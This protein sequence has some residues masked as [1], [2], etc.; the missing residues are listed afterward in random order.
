MKFI[1]TSQGI[2]SHGHMTRHRPTYVRNYIYG[3]GKS[4]IY[5]VLIYKIFCL[6]YIIWKTKY[7]FKLNHVHVSAFEN[8]VQFAHRCLP[9]GFLFP[10]NQCLEYLCLGVV[11][12]AHDYLLNF[13]IIYPKLNSN[14]LKVKSD[15]AGD[16]R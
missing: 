1:F 2:H 12:I 9:T 8:T 16:C 6:T 3:S 5:T 4:Q 11:R 10:R 13:D 7:L 14:Q 15:Q